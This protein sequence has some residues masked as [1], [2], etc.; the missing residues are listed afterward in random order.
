MCA[1]CV[2]RWIEIVASGTRKPRSAR[3][4]HNQFPLL[5]DRS[6]GATWPIGQSACL[7]ARRR[8][9]AA[10]CSIFSRNRPYHGNPLLLLLGSAEKVSRIG[11]IIS[12]PVIARP[13]TTLSMLIRAI[14]IMVIAFLERGSKRDLRGLCWN[15]SSPD[16]FFF[17]KIF[18]S[19]YG[20]SNKWEEKGRQNLSFFPFDGASKMLRVEKKIFSF[21]L[22]W[23]RESC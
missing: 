9:V 1:W 18:L 4:E 23:W 13:I 5:A 3:I 11:T 10:C 21:S 8:S 14:G 6:C 17:F 15:R 22:N 2:T 12:R 16:W 7:D 20:I 19:F